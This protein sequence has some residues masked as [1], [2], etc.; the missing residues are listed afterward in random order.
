MSLLKSAPESM[1]PGLSLPMSVLCS[2]SGTGPTVDPGA[3]T[4]AVGA[5]VGQGLMIVTL[6]KPSRLVSHTISGLLQRL[7]PDLP[8]FNV[9]QRY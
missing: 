2:H 8:L 4:A 5:D 6:F 3:N 9:H 1:F 7:G